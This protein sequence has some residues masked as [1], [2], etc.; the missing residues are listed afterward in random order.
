MSLNLSEV[1]ELIVWNL[2]KSDNVS[3][4]T[5]LNNGKISFLSVRS[6]AVI[7]LIQL[8]KTLVDVAS[9]ILYFAAIEL[10]YAFVYYISVVE[11]SSH[12]LERAASLYLLDLKKLQR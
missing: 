6:N 2:A 9:S 8:I 5:R 7:F 11:Q 12:F 1:R 3:S 4:V 10:L